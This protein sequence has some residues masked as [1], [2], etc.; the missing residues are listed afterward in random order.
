[1]KATTRKYIEKILPLPAIN[2]TKQIFH[3]N[4]TL[5]AQRKES[6]NIAVYVYDYNASELH[7]Y[8]LKTVE[9]TFPFKDNL[10]T[11]WIN[12]DGL[13]KADVH[14]V[15]TYYNIHYLIEEDILSIGQRP[16]WDDIENCIYCLL[17]MLYFNE[18]SF[19]IEQEQISIVL[20]KNFVI[21][22]QEDATRDVLNP[23]REKL[24]FTGSK[25]R[26]SG[27]DY[28]CYLL[29]DILV[30]N[31]YIVLD[32]LSEKIEWLEEE[33]IRYENRA[34]L[35]ARINDFR[36]ELIVLKR[37]IVPV[38]DIVNGFIRSDNAL[39]DANTIK[40]FKD[41]YDHSVQAAD[42]VENYRE[43]MLNMQDLYLNQANLKLNEIM[44]V[45]AIV[46]C[47]LAPATVIGGIF[48]MNFDRI[49][50]LHNHYG[51][52]ITVAIMLFIPL[53]MIRFFKRRGWF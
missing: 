19:T 11:T 43:M 33:I 41:V 6:E 44:K 39:L 52:Y 2:R 27:A 10:N 26:S 34:E 51:F 14:A 20:G 29:I 12:I 5:P 28:L 31:Y 30:D 7:E 18:D 17:Y 16:K 9:E 1:M 8:A 48:G 42:M 40:Y 32:K 47:L 53:I 50:W 24:Q 37:N 3:I 45:M 15:C 35:L 38:R 13:R 21:T 36:K 4:P 46:T 49:P 23:I 22:F 25:L